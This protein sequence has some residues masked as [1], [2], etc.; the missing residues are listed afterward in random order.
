MFLPENK[1]RMS[2][3]SDE[4]GSAL[5]EVAVSSVLLLTLMLG[6]LDTSRALYVDNFVSNSAR[7]AVRY[8]AV[9]GSTWSGTSCAT[10]TTSACMATA[11]NVSIFTD[12]LAPAGVSTSPTYLTVTTQ[13]P[14]TT[15]S[16]ASCSTNGVNN[17]PG[18]VV[19][20]AVSYSFSY[21]L[22]F[23]PKNAM[24]LTSTSTMVIA[25]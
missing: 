17:A 5:I 22:P 13:W 21:I 4:R 25:Q 8:A 14:G 24:A 19:R 1:K 12:G 23:L 16:G 18:C 7:E 15:P 20:V 9:R 6:I 3:A 10:A 11:A 2:F